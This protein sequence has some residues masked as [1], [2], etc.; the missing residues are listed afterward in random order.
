MF[1]ALWGLIV[2][3]AALGL[4]F[5]PFALA[6]YRKHR[7]SDAILLVNLL[8]GWTGLGWIVALIW[9]ATATDGKRA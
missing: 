2:L 1:D 6:K 5:L 7:Q 4:Y 3:C 8:L 9:S